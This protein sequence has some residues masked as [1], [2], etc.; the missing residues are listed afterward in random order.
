M[1]G[2][3]VKHSDRSGVTG[4]G[5]IEWWPHYANVRAILE[6]DTERVYST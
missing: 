5:K 6:G 4:S 3:L 1:G 2:W